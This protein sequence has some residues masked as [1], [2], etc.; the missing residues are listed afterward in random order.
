[1]EILNRFTNAVIFSIAGNSLQNA[2]LQGANLQG[3]NLR[4]AD[5]RYADLRGADLGYADLWYAKLQDADLRYATFRGATFRG[6]ILKSN[7]I[8]I[9][10][11]LWEV[12]ITNEFMTIG[13]Q[14]HTHLQW[15]NF[16]DNQIDDMDPRALELWGKFKEPLLTLCAVQ[17]EVKW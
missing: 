13:C 12:T 8:F 16:A 14:R 9:S 5:L 1:M 11:S 2:D 6:E 17:G 10:C 4:Y 3:A 15:L 7:P